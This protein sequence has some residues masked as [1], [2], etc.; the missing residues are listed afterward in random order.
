MVGAIASE[1]Q[2]SAGH[3]A[4]RALLGQSRR[5]VFQ[6]VISTLVIW[7]SDAVRKRVLPACSARSLNSGS[8]SSLGPRRLAALVLPLGP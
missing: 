6:S 3:W 2:P 8:G 5:S 4:T 7:A 1:N